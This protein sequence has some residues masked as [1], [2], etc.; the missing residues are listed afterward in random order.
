MIQ[1][2]PRTVIL[3]G[4]VQSGLMSLVLYSL[5]RSY[6]ASI[7]GIGE[8][9][10]AL[11]LVFVGTGL[12]T[13]HGR[14]HDFFSVSIARFL[15]VSGL[16]LAYVGSQRFFGVK[17][18][19]R[20]WMTLITGVALIQMW[21]TFVQPNYHAR[22]A[23]ANILAGYLFAVHALLVFKQGASTFARG[24]TL[25]V[26]AAMSAIQW[27][28][29]VTSFIWPMGQDVF[30]T[31]PHHVVYVTSLVFCILL[32]S[33]SMVLMATE[34]LRTKL[35]HL[36]KHDS[37]TNALTRR[38]MNEACAQELERCRR[39]G[40]SMALL[41][42]DLDHFKSINDSYGHQAGDL[43]L[44]NFVS[45]VNALLRQPD[46]LGRFGGEEFVALLPDT[47]LDEAILVAE[48][49]RAAC[50]LAEH[51]P[52]CTVSIGVTTNQ[53]DKDTVDTLLARAD[54]AMYRAKASGRNR[55]ETA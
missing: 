11:L 49:I 24:L 42:M 6:P 18:R 2:D 22:L 13:G 36:A 34:R 55:V 9:A 39:H 38:H 15:I 25:G 16:Y 12:A 48:R 8:W 45:M 7:K 17:P 41:V 26:L 5:K 19:V 23:L 20:A 51:P 27:M 54:A 35:E 21:F 32:L 31:A 40:R 28:R 3:L 46:Q 33:V 10:A 14:L 4:G 52:A 44:V 43:V 1:I 30:E 29:L 53:K 50:A 37:L 47:S